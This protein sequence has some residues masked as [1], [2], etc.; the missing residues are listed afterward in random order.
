MI[1][2]SEVANRF[3]R[4]RPGFELVHA[5][6]VGLP[7]FVLV[8]DVLIQQR[9][10][11]GPIEEFVLRAVEAGLGQI[12]QIAGLLGLDRPIVEAAVLELAQRDSVDYRVENGVR[13]LRVSEFGYRALR[14]WEEM[15]PTRQ[16]VKIGFDRLVWEPTGR[17]YRKLIR[18]K[19]AKEG[20]LDVLPPTWKK[21]VGPADIDL[22]KAQSAM[23]E[24]A[25]KSLAN[26]ELIAIRDVRNYQMVLPAIA[27]VFAQER[28]DGQQIAI[29]IDGQLSDDHEKSFAKIDGPD[30]CNLRVGRA[31]PLAEYPTLG[32][33]VEQVLSRDA[34]TA[35]Q[36]RIAD[37]SVRLVRAQAV[38]ATTEAADEDVR[39]ADAEERESVALLEQAQNDLIN[40]PARP[41]QTYE[42]A[43]LLKE[44]LSGARERLLIISPWIRGDVVDRVFL[45][46]LR[47]RLRAGVEVSIG[48]GISDETDEL[49]AQPLRQLEELMTQERRFQIHRL[50]NTHAKVLIWDNKL[51]VTSFNWLS[52]KGD[53]S[54]RFRQEEGILV[55][56]PDVVE[57]E[58]VK[59]RDQIRAG[60]H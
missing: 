59:Y 41:I 44:A 18:P 2:I 17:N 33:S 19:H 27:L 48:W 38:A 60:R 4:H 25:R 47:E 9:K 40:M 5:E 36:G 8:L 45:R 26:A 3:A 35:M 49:A 54:R 23:V 34:V 32:P 12:D 30:R 39:A 55:N 10:P 42:H 16:E 22:S 13:V 56:M 53:P 20:N 37:A 21:R 11:I 31:A 50:G 51:V 57:S 7:F 1:E 14:G 28:G 29:A 15:V 52:F 6:A 43:V 46:S 58:Y 24:I